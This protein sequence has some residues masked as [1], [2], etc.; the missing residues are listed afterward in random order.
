MYPLTVFCPLRPPARC[1]V[2]W[3]AW[4]LAVLSAGLGGSAWAAGWRTHVVDDSLSQVAAGVVPF[5]WRSVGPSRRDEPPLEA[6]TEVRIVL[7]TA[8]W[9]GQPA[10][11]Y[12]VLP[13]QP[14]APSLAVQW[15][16]RGVL[17]PGRLTGGQRQLVFQGAVPGPQ[18]QDLLQVTAWAR[19]D[20]AALPSRLNF[21]FEIEVPSP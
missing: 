4:A 6:S 10:R 18:M 13:P 11:I 21:S 16:T 14:G 12:M 15:A 2:V 8:A 19:G 7:Q 17:L 3:L 20:D 9:V 1:R 5:R